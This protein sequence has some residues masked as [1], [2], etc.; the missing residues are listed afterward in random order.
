MSAMT[1]EDSSGVIDRSEPGAAGSSDDALDAPRLDTG[2]E[3][4]STTIEEEFG[5]ELVMSITVLGKELVTSM[6]VLGKELVRSMTSSLMTA[7]AAGST[8]SA[9]AC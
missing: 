7:G 1:D 5:K 8:S 4:T 9:G 6:T 2:E 3:M